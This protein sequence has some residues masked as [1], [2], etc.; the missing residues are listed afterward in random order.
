MSFGDKQKE[1]ARKANLNFLLQTNSPQMLEERK[2]IH[3]QML[4]PDNKTEILLP[5]EWLVPAPV[6]WNFFPPISEEKMVEMIFSIINNGLFNPIIVWERIPEK[7]YM[8]LSGHNRVRAYKRLLEEYRDVEGFNEE[9]YKRIPAFIY[10]KDEIDEMKAKEIIIETNYV[11]RDPQDIQRVEHLI[12]KYRMEY[13]FQQKDYKGRTRLK[14]ARELK[15]GQA[16]IQRDYE[17]TTRIIPEFQE[18][19]YQKKCSKTNVIRLKHLP[20]DVQRWF[21]YTYKHLFEGD[22]KSI[23]KLLRAFNQNV[24]TKEDVIEIVENF[25]KMPDIARLEFKVP[26]EFKEILR[27]EIDEFIQKRVKELSGIIGDTSK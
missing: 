4:R 18:L 6:D 13:A 9:K 14:V 23:N 10:K 20:A 27:K 16:T 19:Y 11:Q 5:L 8:I 3:E 15:K 21:Y 24:Y 1:A 25:E 26:E 12:T 7:E 2:F 22:S 17:L